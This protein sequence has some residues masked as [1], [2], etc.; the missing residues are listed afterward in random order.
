[1]KNSLAI[2]LTL[3]IALS[4]LNAQ[5]VIPLKQPDGYWNQRLLNNYRYP[6]VAKPSFRNSTRLDQLI[7]ANRLYLSLQDAI[8]LALENNL[9]IELSRLNFEI[10]QA[11]LLRSQAGG[12]LRGVPN[13][14]RQ[15]PNSAQAA[16]GTQGGFAGT[17]QAGVGGGGGD[18]GSSVGGAILTQTGTAIPNYDEQFF[19]TW[20]YGRSLSPQANPLLTGQTNLSSANNSWNF[21][22]NK[23]F[24]TGG[25]LQVLMTN[26]AIETNN[27]NLLI[28]P[29]TRSGLGGTFTQP[30]LQGF[31]RKVNE[32]N[33]IS[34]RNNL[35]VTDLSFKQQIISTVSSVI[36]LYTDLVSF[37]EDVRVKRQALAYAE[38]L[39]NDNKKQV[40]IGTLAPIEV[41]KAEAEVAARQQDLTV[42]ETQLLQQEV[43]LKN[44]LSR[45][46]VVDVAFANARIMP[47]DRLQTPTAE[48]VEPLQDLVERALSKR[49]ELEQTRL[50]LES[51]QAQLE[52]S[53]S[54]I[55]P[56]LNLI[57]GWTN[58]AQ[59]GTAVALDSQGRP[60]A[61]P[62]QFVGGYSRIIQQLAG[63]DARDWSVQLQY[64]IPLRNRVARADAVRDQMTVRQAEIQ[65]QQ[66][67]NSIRVSVSNALI[68]LQQAQA[69]YQAAIKTRELQ[70]QSLEAEQKKYALGASTIFFVIQAQRD[71]ANAQGQEVQAMSTYSRAKT[72]LEVATGTL[73]DSYNIDLQEAKDAQ[74]KRA[75]SEFIPVP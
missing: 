34:A 28:N 59:A 49:P 40:E 48:K 52:G 14:I 43:I 18:Q 71:L 50:N 13:Q 39:Y 12:A 7:R 66:Q 5:Q 51:S 32:R 16:L 11:D 23:G 41:V 67:V 75:P 61:I 10:A 56:Q 2:L 73:L 54:L 15:G 27:R 35:R 45:S 30:L 9:D 26:S 31:G 37:A 22:F 60:I 47:T 44:A 19:A 36:N 53:K 70:E 65:Q 55:R 24:W 46:G 62:T 4:P 68:Q 6:I 33:I 58:N 69:R 57:T 42:S 29:F 1:M 8:A 72:Q 74:V 63:F 38:K 3:S 17:S 25:Q 20:S 64:S 21:G